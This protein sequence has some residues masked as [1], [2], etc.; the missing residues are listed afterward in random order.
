MTTVPTGQVKDDAHR[1]PDGSAYPHPS[2]HER[3]FKAEHSASGQCPRGVARVFPL[4]S[5]RVT[6]PCGPVISCPVEVHTLE[7]I[8]TFPKNSIAALD[9]HPQERIR[10]IDLLNSLMVET[11]ECGQ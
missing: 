2:I 8:G 3:V 6:L 5:V 10:K 1:P 7:E 9:N 4:V 11:G